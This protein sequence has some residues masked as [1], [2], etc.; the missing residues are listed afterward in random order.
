MKLLI[1]SSLQ[2]L[3]NLIY[4]KNIIPCIPMVNGIISAYY[5]FYHI[6]DN[7]TNIL[8]M[9]YM[10]YMSFNFYNLFIFVCTS[11][12]LILNTGYDE[13]YTLCV[14]APLN[15]MIARYLGAYSPHL[16]AF[17]C[18]FISIF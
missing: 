4:T 15:L 3:G 12:M 18:W 6:V 17:G 2:F 9:M 16:L 14:H 10:L 5:P 1:A 8:L 13:S 11:N 7:C